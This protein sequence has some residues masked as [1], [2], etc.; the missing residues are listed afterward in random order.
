MRKCLLVT[1]SVAVLAILSGQ[2]GPVKHDG[3]PGDPLADQMKQ[4]HQRLVKELQL[5]DKPRADVD[6]LLADYRSRTIAWMKQYG[7]EMRKLRQRIGSAR[8][9]QDVEAAKQTQLDR[10][11]LGK[12]RK[13]RQQMIKDLI[14]ALGKI[15][16][17]KQLAKARKVLDPKPPMPIP[18]PRFYLLN[19]LDL[20]A[21]QRAEIE[22]IIKAAES[23]NPETKRK[24]LR[25]AWDRIVKEVLTEKDRRR[26]EEQKKASR[27]R[28]IRSMFKGIELTEK[29]YEAIEQVFEGVRKKAA[30]NPDDR[31]ASFQ[32]G[33]KEILENVLTPEQ[34]EAYQKGNTR[35]HAENPHHR[36]PEAP[37]K[38][39]PKAK[40]K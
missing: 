6:D 9:V 4:S 37:A 24:Q 1:A 38:D 40:R 12:L 22:K 15:L 39:D 27:R 7:P 13:Q 11:R 2:A 10:T 5:S 20:T 17:P 32:A 21:K 8:G 3:K 28:V 30:E 14:A 33:L 34:R 16:D 19:R 25:Q 31:M 35:W 26:L 36:P 23:K 18:S 29:Q